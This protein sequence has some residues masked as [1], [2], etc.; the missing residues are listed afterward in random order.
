M[1]DD[2]SLESDALAEAYSIAWRVGMRNDTKASV[3]PDSG[4]QAGPEEKA[5]YTMDALA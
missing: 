5:V 2:G 1:A 4:G 3:G